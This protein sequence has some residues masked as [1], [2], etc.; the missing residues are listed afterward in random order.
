MLK[1]SAGVAWG[2]GYITCLGHGIIMFAVTLI[3]LFFRLRV[4][5]L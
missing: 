2:K 4:R 3:Y 1:R 5:A